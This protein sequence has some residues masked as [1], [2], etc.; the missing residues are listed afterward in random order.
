M[1]QRQFGAT[2][3]VDTVRLSLLQLASGSVQQEIVFCERDGHS[4]L[5]A[6]RD[7]TF[8]AVDA[9][10]NP[11]IVGEAGVSAYPTFKFY[12]NTAEEDLPVVGADIAEVQAKLDELLAA[13]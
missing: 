5:E 3:E 13:G 12:R 2:S 10:E 4:T 11:V 9:D 6:Y 7:V 8:L 1:L